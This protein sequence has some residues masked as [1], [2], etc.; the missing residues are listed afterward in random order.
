MQAD[1]PREAEV[2]QLLKHTL[3]HF[4]GLDIF[5]NNAARLCLAMPQ[6]VLRKV[7]LDGPSSCCSCVQDIQ[8]EE[9]SD[10]DSELQI[11][12]GTQLSWSSRANMWVRHWLLVQT[13][14]EF[15]AQT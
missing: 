11:M 8:C 6:K 7:L 13:G 9:Q 2:A 4:S 1:R 5:V 3:E 15:W 14:R 10:A 12:P